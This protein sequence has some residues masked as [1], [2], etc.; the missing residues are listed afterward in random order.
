MLKEAII[1]E[2]GC[3]EIEII[4][5]VWNEKNFEEFELAFFMIT[6]FEAVYKS[7]LLSNTK[8]LFFKLQE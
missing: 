7:S 6:Y 8:I 4:F 3:I 1:I 5:V 2:L